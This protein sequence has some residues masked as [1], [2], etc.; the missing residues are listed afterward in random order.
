MDRE[1]KQRR[2]VA[3][4]GPPNRW[5]IIGS[6]ASWLAILGLVSL[7][8]SL[9]QAQDEVPLRLLPPLGP[10]TPLE[11]EVEEILETP[12]GVADPAVGWMTPA[13]W[14]TSPLWDFG[15]E[16]G[17]NGSEG[18]TQSFS[19][20]ASTSLQR[21]TEGNT[22]DLGLTYGKTQANGAETQNYALLN[23]RWDLNM[24]PQWFLYNKDVVEYDEF[25]AFDLRL[26][27]SGGLGYHFLKNEATTMTGRLGAGV[28]REFG[29]PDESWVP[30]ANMGLDFE[31]QLS[32]R[33]KVKVSSD[34]YP[35]WEDFLDYRLLLNANWEILLDEET[36]L[37][38]KLGLIDRYDSTPNGREHNDLDYFIT[39]VWKL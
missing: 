38:L 12:M 24:S 9:L 35:A 10:E 33:Q 16:L 29:G 18:N 27:V 39:L 28:S 17:V 23:S 14:F 25:K 32:A 37:S 1:E 34:Y 8:A 5:P 26:V 31:H 2:G 22:F 4:G 6:R 36:N 20:L 13:T 21:K 15:M 7:A 11:T 19:L 30:E 3:R